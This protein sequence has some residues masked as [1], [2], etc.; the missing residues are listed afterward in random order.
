MAYLE[1]AGQEFGQLP[2]L[3]QGFCPALARHIIQR[4][5]HSSDPERAIGPPTFHSH[6]PTPLLPALTLSVG[7]CKVRAGEC[8]ASAGEVPSSDVW[9]C[10]ATLALNRHCRNGIMQAYPAGVSG[11]ATLWTVCLDLTAGKGAMLPTD[12]AV[13][14][15]LHTLAFGCLDDLLVEWFSFPESTDGAILAANTKSNYSRK[16][17]RMVFWTA[18]KE[19]AYIYLPICSP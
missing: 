15:S 9:S 17:D 5:R 19:W 8:K 3:A 18:L 11:P 7:E 1:I 4:A 2:G 13:D 16:G 12:T 14:P 6:P 10:V